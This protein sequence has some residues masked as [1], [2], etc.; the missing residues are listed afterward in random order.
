V[1]KK[2]KFE[3][4]SKITLL[5]YELVADANVPDVSGKPLNKPIAYGTNVLLFPLYT[6]NVISP[7]GVVADTFA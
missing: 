6:P 4:V 5:M 2:L 3:P 7:I 1:L